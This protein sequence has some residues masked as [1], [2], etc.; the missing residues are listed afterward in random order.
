MSCQSSLSLVGCASTAIKYTSTDRLD[1]S[2]D[3]WTATGDRA[4][5]LEEQERGEAH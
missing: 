5:H 4:S 3:K 1:T 2:V